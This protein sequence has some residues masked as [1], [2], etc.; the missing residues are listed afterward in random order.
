[1]APRTP[2]L[3]PKQAAFA[4]VHRINPV[5]FWGRVDARCPESCW[6]WQ[7]AKDRG[8]YGRVQFAGVHA[9]SLAHRVAYGLTHGELPAAVCHTCDNPS[10]CNPAHLIGADRAYNNW[11]MVRKGRHAAQTGTQNPVRGSSHPAAKLNELVAGEIR[12]RYAKSKVTQRDL[13]REYGVCQRT[14]NK[15]VRGAT[16]VAA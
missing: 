11:D 12:Q 14:I 6:N 9:P 3:T 4:Q 1:M 13:A 10:C 2:A 8:G 7:G 15:I 5:A 16:Y